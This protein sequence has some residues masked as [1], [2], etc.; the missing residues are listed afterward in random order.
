MR[1]GIKV[2]LPEEVQLARAYSRLTAKAQTTVPKKVREVL[3]LEP[4]D[5]LVYE[6]E[7][8]QVRLAKLPRAD[9]VHLRALQATLSEWETPE[10]AAAFDDL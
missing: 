7:D 4:G 3:S 1:Q 10:D 6:I 5:A 2:S 8:G 9:D